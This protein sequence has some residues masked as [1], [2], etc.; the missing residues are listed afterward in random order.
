M[1]GFFAISR[2]TFQRGRASL[3]PMGYK[4]GLELMVRCRCTKV[5]DVPITFRDREAG[6]SKL[7]MKQNLYYLMHLA[8]LYWFKY[9]LQVI[10]ALLGALAAAYAVL[11]YLALLFAKVKQ[12]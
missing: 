11:T 3:N 8:H 1:S 9:P 12:N 4:I 6:E 10:L 2:D 7:T 5:V